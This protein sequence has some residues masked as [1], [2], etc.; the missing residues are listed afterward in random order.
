M[1]ANYDWGV[2]KV[3][4]KSEPFK[5]RFLKI[6]SSNYFATFTLRVSLITVTFT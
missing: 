4:K 3:Q 5:A 6:F 1:Q 2:P